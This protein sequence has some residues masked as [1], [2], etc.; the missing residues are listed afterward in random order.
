[1]SDGP[2]G[3]GALQRQTEKMINA[4]LPTNGGQ[5]DVAAEADSTGAAGVEG[6][7]AAGGSWWSV[8]A[9]GQWMRDRG[10]STGGLGSLRWGSRR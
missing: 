2:F 7:I 8:G 3:P 10:W 4:P 1:M 5:L 9:W 6:R